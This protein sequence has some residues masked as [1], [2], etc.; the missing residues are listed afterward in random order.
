MAKRQWR[1][2][3]I[4]GEFPTLG[5]IVA[6]WI[7]A[8]CAIPDRHVAGQPFKL[9]DEQLKH[10]IWEYRL[11]PK[12]K[13]DLEKPSAPFVYDGNVLVRSQKWGKGPLSAARICAQAAGP[14]LFAGW[15]DEGE[16]TG[17]PW[18]TPHI[19]VT[20][21]AE[22]QTKNIWRA[23]IPMIELGAIAAEIDN[24]GL[25]QIYLP[26]DGL[27]E[28]VTSAAISKLGARITYAEQ[29]QTE[30][31]LEANGG[32]KLADTQRRNLGGTGGRWSAS[33]NA[34]DPAENSV[35]QQDFEMV[36]SGEVTDVFVNYPTPVEGS[37]QDKRNR[38][39]ILKHAYKGAPWVDLNRIEAECRRLDAKKDPG[40][41]E[42]FYGNRIV[43]GAS[44]A[45]DLTAYKKLRDDERTI[46]PGRIVTVGFDGALTRDATG[47]VVTDAELG[48]Q[49][50]VGLWERPRNL[51]DDEPWIVPVDEVDE[52]VAHIFDTWDVWDFYAD[53]PHWKEDINRWAGEYGE[54]K[55]T[56]WWTNQRK[57]MAYSLKQFATDQ[58]E[59]VMSYG[60][61]HADDLERHIGNAVRRLTQMRDEDDQTLLWLIGKDGHNS[62][63]RID[64][65]MAACLSWEARGDCVR[66]GEH[67]KKKRRYASW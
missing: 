11:H 64:L 22:D 38:R 67:V 4:P 59:G 28:R 49:L 53:P 8:N 62:P 7:E 32:I 23:L 39:R 25:Q 57:K 34:W 20:A 26:D 56:L 30:S 13:V 60:G 33:C 19:Q 6:D 1:G 55:V 48:H 42:R 52:A 5:Y 2:A 16:P 46:E 21:T 58:R 41:A 40:Q 24:T 54:D 3:E 61:E 36:E 10:L 27:I 47:L 37:W 31:M 15:D 29:D 50:A 12:A 43:A 66:K 18:S 35:A 17:M 9:S 44:K 45:F 51:R 63:R 14:V 65:A